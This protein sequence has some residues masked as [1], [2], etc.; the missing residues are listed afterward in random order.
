M[1]ACFY[2]RHRA[3]KSGGP[4]IFWSAALL[5]VPFYALISK[6]KLDS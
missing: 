3:T 5:S 4:R 2:G 1:G 6:G